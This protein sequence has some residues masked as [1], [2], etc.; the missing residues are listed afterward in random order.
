MYSFS[1]FRLTKYVN[2]KQ[3]IL[4]YTLTDIK[5]TN[6]ETRVSLLLTN[7]LYTQQTNIKIIMS[8]ELNCHCAVNTTSQQTLRNI[9]QVQKRRRLVHV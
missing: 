2:L 3:Q 1:C 7:H 5:T 6:Y 4:I 9:V 8:A